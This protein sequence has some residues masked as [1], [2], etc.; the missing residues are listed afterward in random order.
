[1]DVAAAARAAAFWAG[2]H[3]LLLLVLSAVAAQRRQRFQVGPD[4]PAPPALAQ[5]VGA[6]S[7]AAEYI[8]AALAAIVALTVVGAPAGLVHL[9]GF[10][11]FAGRIAQAAGLLQDAGASALRSVG[12]LITW[13]AYLGAAVSLLF[14]AIP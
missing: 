4:A 11:L 8:P 7:N 2:L 5:A 12:V 9:A 6:F 13:V 1:M 10:S 3:L 14:F